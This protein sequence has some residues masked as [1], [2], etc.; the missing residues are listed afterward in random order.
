MTAYLTMECVCSDGSSVLWHCCSRVLARSL[1]LSWEIQM[2]DR[3]QSGQSYFWHAILYLWV[4]YTAYH[5][6]PYCFVTAM[7]FSLFLKCRFVT[8]VLLS[9]WRTVL[10]VEQQN[11]IGV[12]FYDLFLLICYC[13]KYSFV[14]LVNTVLLS[15]VIYHWL[16]CRRSTVICLLGCDLFQVTVL[17][18]CLQ[19]RYLLF[20][21]R[22]CS[23]RHS[24]HCSG[25]YVMMCVCWC[26]CVCVCL[27]VCVCMSDNICVSWFILDFNIQCL[28]SFTY[29]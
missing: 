9:Q 15:S 26:V 18:Y 20:G 29:S 8:V 14:T 28:E 16:N 25:L 23:L 7:L 5:H 3:Q 19:W 27:C 2:S 10:F 13:G 11:S 6:Q 1:I 4:V 21:A 22:H 17:G 12:T 24:V